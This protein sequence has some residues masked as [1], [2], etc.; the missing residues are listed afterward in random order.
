MI[1]FFTQ[2]F[3]NMKSRFFNN[4]FKNFI[5]IFFRIVGGVFPIFTYYILQ[6]ITTIEV[7]AQIVGYLSVIFV[8]STFFRFGFDQYILKIGVNDTAGSDVTKLIMMK[9]S[10]F[11]FFISSTMSLL[12]YIVSFFVE[13]QL[14]VLHFIVISFFVSLLNIGF[15]Y[16]SSQSMKIRSVCFFHISPHLILILSLFFT[17][18]VFLIL[19]LS[20]CL[21]CFYL[22]RFFKFDKLSLVNLFSFSKIKFGDFYKIYLVS[23]LSILFANIPVMYALYLSDDESIYLSG[24][25]IR[26]IGLASFISTIIYT[27]YAREIKS[28]KI[29]YRLH[30]K[31]FPILY[32]LILLC[33]S[34]ILFAYLILNDYQYLVMS[35]GGNFEYSVGFYFLM[36]F[37]FPVITIGNVIGY[38][39]LVNDFIYILVFSLA[40]SVLLLLSLFYFIPADSVLYIITFYIFALVFDGLVKILY[41]FN[42]IRVGEFYD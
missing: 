33:I 4:L 9:F 26:I 32:F 2:D 1:D 29:D 14:T 30:F 34:F 37:L 39:L 36:F 42:K 22:L 20:Y 19:L 18:N 15:S 13:V 12:W 3:S 40:S 6:Y 23:L 31:L 41:Y 35:W 27:L 21:P 38:L 24:L 5:L 11:I 25:Y 7:S 28:L 17:D 10:L 8:V 16:F